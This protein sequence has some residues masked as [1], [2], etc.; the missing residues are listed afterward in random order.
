MI[1]TKTC[2]NCESEHRLHVKKCGC[3]HVFETKQ[4]S[5]EPTV[6]RAEILRR[7]ESRIRQRMA[8]FN[9]TPAKEFVAANPSKVWAYRI[10]DRQAKGD[11]VPHIA[12]EFARQVVGEMNNT[13]NM[14]AV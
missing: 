14:E 3:G 10:L 2:P 12:I 1:Q 6:S 9:G 13:M 4:E 11:S 8:E 7:Y 5:T